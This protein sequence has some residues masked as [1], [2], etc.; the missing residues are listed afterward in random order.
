V[1]TG[2]VAAGALLAGSASLAVALTAVGAVLGSGRRHRRL[3]AQVDL[4][5]GAAAALLDP[6]EPEGAPRPSPAVAAAGAVP[7]PSSDAAL[8]AAD[9]SRFP[10]LADVPGPL[11]GLER[12]LRLVAAALTADRRRVNLLE[13]AVRSVP[14]GLVLTDERGEV[15]FLND[16]AAE[17]A[18]GRHGD[19]L[20]DAAVRDLV[21]EA[22][23]EGQS[24]TRTLDLFGPPRRTMVVSARPVLAAGEPVGGL[25]VIADI[26]EKRRLEAIRRDFVANI[27]H[28][29]KT[30]VGALSL[31]AETIISEE[32]P[33]VTRRLAER[34]V[35]EATRLAST[36]EDLLLLS[37]IESEERAEHGELAVHRLVSEAV[38]RI[39]PAAGNVG[40]TLDAPEPY[41][42]LDLARSRQ[43][44]GTG[45]GLSIVR[46]VMANHGGEVTVES[47]LGE[48][49]TF[50]LH[51][52]VAEP[53]V[54]PDP[55]GSAP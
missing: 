5:D 42:R 25:A 28:E 47:R 54:D 48:G 27:S 52:P 18:G 31:L 30:P 37:R 17:F 40:I 43:T 32:D 41:S 23:Q 24:G 26:T 36:I 44:G 3:L 53:V 38:N 34:M 11:E 33:Q 12:R 10:A 7:V 9:P 21:D 13:R 2:A 55:D 16:V 20:V 29:L 4:L 22:V 45:L 19:A 8:S 14:E 39:R 35:S 50:A 46:H 51:L 6:L 1:V 15:V 49:S